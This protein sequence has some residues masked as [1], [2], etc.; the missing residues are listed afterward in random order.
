MLTTESCRFLSVNSANRKETLS[1][2]GASFQRIS[3]LHA[4]ELS[5]DSVLLSNFIINFPFYRFCLQTVTVLEL[6]QVKK[7]ICWLILQWSGWSAALTLA[8]AGLNFNS[9]PDTEDLGCFSLKDI[10]WQQAQSLGSPVRALQQNQTDNELCV[11]GAFE[12]L[13][14]TGG[15]FG[16]LQE[17]EELPFPLGEVLTFNFLLTTI[18]H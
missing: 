1:T 14:Q 6:L 3:M 9:L 4:C 7:L 5:E 18:Y 16:L 10:Q 8:S 12:S 2:T 17:A 11:W 15:Y 13:C